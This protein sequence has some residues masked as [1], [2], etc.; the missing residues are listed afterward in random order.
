M[1]LEPET[2]DKLRK[3]ASDFL[4]AERR[5]LKRLDEGLFPTASAAEIL[6]SQLQMH[7]RLRTRL[8]LL[9][10]QVDRERAE[11]VLREQQATRLEQQAQQQQQEHER[12]AGLIAQREAWFDQQNALLGAIDEDIAR[13]QK[14]LAA[15]QDEIE[16]LPPAE[17]GEIAEL[18]RKLARLEECKVLSA[19]HGIDTVR[20]RIEKLGEMGTMLAREGVE[21]V[22]LPGYRLLKEARQRFGADESLTADRL[23]EVTVEEVSRAS[24]ELNKARDTYSK[25]ILAVHAA[26]AERSGRLA[27]AEW[28]AAETDAFQRFARARKR[29]SKATAHQLIR[30]LARDGE[31]KLCQLESELFAKSAKSEWLEAESFADQKWTSIQSKWKE[32]HGQAS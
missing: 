13:R 28:R 31:W 22:R 18:R 12:I 20:A 24:D 2:N 30:K 15:E 21:L 5:L 7:E 26:N 23:K 3:L 19:G 29:T 8:A 16:E 11:I 4:I 32:A 27:E 14:E 6:Y 9:K 1:A 25:Q 10:T 17:D